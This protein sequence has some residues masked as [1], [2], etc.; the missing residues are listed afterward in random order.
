[1]SNFF[2]D[3]KRT[4]LERLSRYSVRYDRW[5]MKEF[6]QLL[7]QQPS[8]SAARQRL[9]D[10]IAGELG[11]DEAADVI[12]MLNKVR[13][14]LIPPTEIRPSRLLNRHVNEEV[15]RLPQLENLRRFTQGDPVASALAF[16][17]MG[18]TLETLYDKF[19]QQIKKQ[20]EYEEKLQRALQAKSDEQTAE[21]MLQQ[22]LDKEEDDEDGEG[23]QEDEEDE[24]KAQLEAAAQ[25][26]QDEAADADQ[27]AQA[28]LADLEAS[29][30]GMT[31]EIQEAM[32][33]ALDEANDYLEVINSMA[34]SWGSD[35]GELMRL[36]AKKR[37]ELAKRLNTPK[38]QQMSKLLGPMVREAFAAQ[39]RKQVYTPEEIFDLTLG[40][41]IPRLLPSELAKFDMEETEMLFLK[42]WYEENLLQYEMRGYEKIARG[43]IIYIHDGSLSMAGP[44]EIWAKGVGLALLHVARKQ[45]RSFYGIQFGSA[46]EIR[47]D[48]FRDT[49][50]IVPEKVI[51]FAEYF[52]NGGTHFMT[53]LKH[54]LDILKKEHAEFGAVRADIVFATDGQ[55]H[56]SPAFMENLKETQRKL[57]F[58]VWGIAIGTDVRAEPLSE[59]CDGKV[60][61]I[62]SLL[63]AK[64]LSEVFR[65]L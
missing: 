16:E 51:D 53:P 21:E 22:Y 18:P 28:A 6:E 36:P 58:Q 1:M 63:N 35:P 39:K 13:P 64:D 24:Q 10:N 47:I 52:F 57:D 26:A 54:A 60:A 23:E 34:S 17:Q 9:A 38:F 32:G 65:G 33:K 42:D 15:L 30:N 40:N 50:N 62:K 7:D 19:G 45:K 8:V 3:R 56:I 14:E 55:A 37:L 61:T 20:Q 29:L 27:E 41:D 25:A 5:D 43:G 12:W 11:Y 48:D 49:K 46:S 59:L 4:N 44:P 2:E 31:P